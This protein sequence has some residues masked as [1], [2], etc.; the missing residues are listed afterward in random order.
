MK[1]LA[2]IAEVK[3]VV[4]YMRVNEFLRN[5]WIL[6]DIFHDENNLF[7]CEVKAVKNKSAFHL[8]VK[9]DKNSK[10]IGQVESAE[11]ASSY[12]MYRFMKLLRDR[13]E[14]DRP[15]R[16][17]KHGRHANEDEAIISRAV[18]PAL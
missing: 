7:L 8:F 3:F 1:N 11:F 6:L 15:G 12:N 18:R 10:Y 14:Y 2:N 13:A 5:F 17:R 9:G 4:N 16:S